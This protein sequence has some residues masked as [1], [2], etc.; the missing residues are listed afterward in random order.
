MDNEKVNI[1]CYTHDCKYNLWHGCNLKNI[2][3][4]DAQC[5]NVELRK[6]LNEMPKNLKQFLK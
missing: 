1:E 6:N 3:I 5:V 4:E 2:S